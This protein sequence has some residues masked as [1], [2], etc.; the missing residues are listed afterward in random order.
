MGTFSNSFSVGG[1]CRSGR[2]IPPIPP[3]PTIL[4]ALL[5]TVGGET[6]FLKTTVSSVDYCLQVTV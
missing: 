2:I 6:F 5:I 3:S 1:F 4:D